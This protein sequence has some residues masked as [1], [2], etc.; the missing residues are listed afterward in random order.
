MTGRFFITGIKD[1]EE[2][3]QI[4]RRI[5]KRVLTGWNL[6]MWIAFSKPVDRHGLRPRDDK[7]GKEW[8]GS[9]HTH[10]CHC[11]EGSAS[12]RR[13]NPSC[14]ERMRTTCLFAYWFTVD[15][16]GLSALAMTRS[17]EDAVCG[18]ECSVRADDH[19][20]SLS[21]RGGNASDRRGNP[22]CLEGT[23][24]TCLFAY[25]FTVDRHGLSALAMTINARNINRLKKF[26]APGISPDEIDQSHFV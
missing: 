6:S 1:T 11:E 12:D 19:T 5:V 7:L 2:L 9:I 16:H 25:W 3:H 14:L 15:R 21:L 23:R 8:W 22:S 24:T 10:S 26:P 17:G 4:F 20:H 13:G 18:E